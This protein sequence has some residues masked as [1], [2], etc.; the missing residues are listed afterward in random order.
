MDQLLQTGEV[1]GVSR[2]QRQAVGQSSRSDQKVGK[3]PARRTP[4]AAHR[5]VKATVGAR[6]VST[7]WERIPVRGRPLEAVLPAAAFLLVHRSVRAGGEFR[8]RDGGERGFVRKVVGVDQVEVKDDGCIEQ[9]A[10]FG[11]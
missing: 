7:K 11:G 6:D 8:E 3:P 5:R 9:T 10:N 4:A 1:C 2:E